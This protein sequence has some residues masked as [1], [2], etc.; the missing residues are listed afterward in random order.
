MQI[1]NKFCL[2]VEMAKVL[3]SLYSQA[4]TRFE[5]TVFIDQR[6]ETQTQNSQRG[7]ER[8]NLSFSHV[9]TFH[10]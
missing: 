9:G 7:Q 6:G 8:K 4:V 10:N 5:F 3:S 2:I 1:P